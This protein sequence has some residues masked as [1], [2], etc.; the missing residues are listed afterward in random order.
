[1]GIF[2]RRRSHLAAVAADDD[3]SLRSGLTPEAA[4]EAY[5]LTLDAAA[6]F[7]GLVDEA[8][9]AY[10]SG[11]EEAYDHAVRVATGFAYDPRN[12]SR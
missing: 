8:H 12:W 3:A 7:V 2:T 5:G 1:M 4:A 10:W 11:S 6:E 9:E